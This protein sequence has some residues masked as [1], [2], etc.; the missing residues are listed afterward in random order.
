[1]SNALLDHALIY[2]SKGLSVIPCRPREKAPDLPSWSCFQQQRASQDTIRHWWTDK[3]DR[4]VGVVT[5]EVSGGLVVLDFDA[6]SA[7]Q[8]YCQN[9]PLLLDTRIHLTGSRKGYHAFYYV[10]IIP[11]SSKYDTKFGRVEVKANGVQVV[12]P[13]SIHPSGNKYSVYFKPKT[14]HVHD[15]NDVL[16]WLKANE[17]RAPRAAVPLPQ[18]GVP[19]NL[20]RATQDFLQR[21]ALEGERNQRLFR[22]ACDMAGNGIAQSEA[23][24]RLL[25][26]TTLPEREVIRTIGSAYQKNR[27]PARPLSDIPKRRNPLVSKFQSKTSS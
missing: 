1:M 18:G 19:E 21:G 24:T 27:V 20:S 10:A 2:N 16:D 9:F 12:A 5:G 7:F 15:L 11:Q 3:P 4:N 6:M 22:A 25:N 23:E 14:R 26:A 8:A 17:K 13:P